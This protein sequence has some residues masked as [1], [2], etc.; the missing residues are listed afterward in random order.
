M[1]FLHLFKSVSIC[2]FLLVWSHMMFPNAMVITY[3]EEFMVMG[4][5]QH[6]GGEM[7]EASSFRTLYFFLCPISIS[8]HSILKS[9]T[10]FQNL[11]SLLPYFLWVGTDIHTKVNV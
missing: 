10:K 4:T 9:G 6:T 8:Y 1:D 2:T 5:T 3:W 11:V 7:I